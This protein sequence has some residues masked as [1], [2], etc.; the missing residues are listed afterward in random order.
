MMDHPR[1]NSWTGSSRP[2][3]PIACAIATRASLSTIC[4]IATVSDTNTSLSTAIC[5]YSGMAHSER[6]VCDACRT[7]VAFSPVISWINSG[8]IPALTIAD[9][10]SSRGRTFNSRS[11]ASTCATRKHT[12]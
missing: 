10:T 12:R 5:R 9:L 3:V 8:M 1:P 11:N 4:L 6:I 7:S 2:Y